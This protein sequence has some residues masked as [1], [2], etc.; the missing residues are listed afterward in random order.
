MI[1]QQYYKN[2][3]SRFISLTILVVILY[4]VFYLVSSVINIPPSNIYKLPAF[5][6]SQR[7]SIILGIR[8]ITTV[9]LCYFLLLY[10]LR[11]FKIYISIIG[12]LIGMISGAIIGLVIAGSIETYLIIVLTFLVV[13]SA[14]AWKVKKITVSILIGVYGLLM[15]SLIYYSAF[16]FIPNIFISTVIFGFSAYLGYKLY[17]YAVILSISLPASSSLFIVLIQPEIFSLIIEVYNDIT[18][19]F[20]FSIY[21][22]QTATEELKQTLNNIIFVLLDHGVTK[23]IY[24]TIL[25][26][27]SIV[28]QKKLK[29]YI[30][31]PSL[32]KRILYIILIV[33]VSSQIIFILTDLPYYATSFTMF[34]L[35]YFSLPVASI[36]I[37][38]TV[39]F[40]LNNF[41]YENNRNRYI[42]IIVTNTIILPI[43][44]I[45]FYKLFTNTRMFD[46]FFTSFYRFEEGLFF[47]KILS[48]LIMLFILDKFIFKYH[49]NTSNYDTDT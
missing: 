31:Y 2:G 45:L 28:Y 25:S 26:L 43:A 19:I 39:V 38:A 23:F 17:D 10:G 32:L 29:S 47:Y 11:L 18:G 7:I 8:T 12:G 49:F 40:L 9:V 34:G 27:L 22:L 36:L 42:L 41:D 33:S 30:R 1:D 15:F 37:Y 48:F 16:N 46:L 6:G 3:K 44:S 21:G 20:K 5:P 35:D 14:I 24:I 13:F 4:G